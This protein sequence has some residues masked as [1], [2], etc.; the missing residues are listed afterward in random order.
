M[1]NP[2]SAAPQSSIASNEYDFT[3]ERRGRAVIIN[4]R[5]FDRARTRQNDRPGTDVDAAALESLLVM[6]G[7][8]VTRHDNMSPTDMSI[9]LR[10]GMLSNKLGF[11]FFI[12]K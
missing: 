9:T 6:M 12:L 7:F 5:E 8:D 3:H 11:L 2:Q 4:N 1:A 10:S